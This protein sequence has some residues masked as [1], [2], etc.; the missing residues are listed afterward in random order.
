MVNSFSI[1]VWINTSIL[2]RIIWANIVNTLND[3]MIHRELAQLNKKKIITWCSSTTLIHV[4]GFQ[5][6]TYLNLKIKVISIPVKN[7][8]NLGPIQNCGTFPLSLC[9]SNEGY[10]FICYR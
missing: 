7:L 8:F 2:I 3:F 9:K 4:Y 5:L 6:F 1:V 10:F